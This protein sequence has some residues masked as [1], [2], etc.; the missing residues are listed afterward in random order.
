MPPKLSDLVKKGIATP[1]SGMD[2][3]IQMEVYIGST[4]YAMDSDSSD[5]DV[6][7]FWIPPLDAI[8]PHLAGHIPGYDNV[9]SNK[10]LKFSTYQSHRMIDPS[11]KGGR[12]QRYDYTIHSIVKFFNLL[13]GANPTLIESLF[14]PERCVLHLTPVGNMVRENRKM[15]LCREL[16]KNSASYARGQ[17]HK[18]RN[19]ETTTESNRF[20]MVQEH[21]YDLKFAC[22][23][24]RL[25]D[26]AYQI[27]TEGDIDIESNCEKL[28]EIR[29]GEWSMEQIEAHFKLMEPLLLEASEKCTLP[30]EPDRERVRALL[31]DCLKK[32]FGSLGN[33][34]VDRN[35]SQVV[36]DQIKELIATSGV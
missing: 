31:I 21:G 30:W 28:K 20:E 34:V 14:S 36:I 32:N 1:P 3:L 17:L 4:A 33:A 35:R 22:H 27:V 5:L 2:Q 25:I 6:L 19:K 29:R 24:V 12:G 11:A 9:F 26:Q 8:F 13:L 16:A 15:F 7:G 18:M 23:N 10:N